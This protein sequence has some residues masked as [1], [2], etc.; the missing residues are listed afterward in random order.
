MQ[1]Q[2]FDYDF[3]AD[4]IVN[5]KVSNTQMTNVNRNDGCCGQKGGKGSWIMSKKLMLR[6]SI[7]EMRHYWHIASNIALNC[8]TKASA[9]DYHVACF[10]IY[11]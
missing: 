2:Q 3:T 1:V 6:S 8:T 4:Q 9:M 5:A 7:V 10:D 11:R